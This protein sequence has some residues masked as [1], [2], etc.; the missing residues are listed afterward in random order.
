MSVFIETPDVVVPGTVF[1][2]LGDRMV[3]STPEI[4]NMIEPN[5]I[6]SQTVFNF[7]PWA[8]SSAN[9][10]G[11]TFPPDENFTSNEHGTMITSWHYFLNGF[12]FQFVLEI[13]D[14]VVD[15]GCNFFLGDALS[16]HIFVCACEVDGTVHAICEHGVVV[17]CW[18]LV[19]RFIN[20][21]SDW[22]LLY[23]LSSQGSLVVAAEREYWSLGCQYDCV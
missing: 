8:D 10:M 15:G 6:K 3:A 13:P 19:D 22:D 17:S 7:V 9:S 21:H 20:G 14:T 2:N 23:A 18:D 1:I 11:L 12:I 5:S 4:F 16:S